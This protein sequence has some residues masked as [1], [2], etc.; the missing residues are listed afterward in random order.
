MTAIKNLRLPIKLLSSAMLITVL[1]VLMA[2]FFV[3]SLRNISRTFQTVHHTVAIEE[4]VEDAQVHMEQADTSNAFASKAQTMDELTSHA[5]QGRKLRNQAVLDLERA[6]AQTSDEEVSR[7]LSDAK[8]KITAYGTLSQ[9]AFLARKTYLETFQSLHADAPKLSEALR[10]SAS[11]ARDAAS[12]LADPLLSAERSFASAQAFMLHYLLTNA[13][14][15]AGLQVQTIQQANT[16]VDDAVARA[17]GTPLEKEVADLADGMQAYSHAVTGLAGLVMESDDIWLN[18]MVS[19]HKSLGKARQAAMDRLGHDTDTAIENTVARIGTDTSLTLAVAAVVLVVVICLNLLTVRLV[20]RPILR[21]T[22]VMELLARGENTV[23]VPYRDQTDEVGGM[24]Q[25]VQI[26][27]E[28]ALRLA[29]ISSEQEALQAQ[30]QADKTEALHALADSLENSVKG[31]AE[32]VAAAAARMQDTAGSL[33][34]IAAET[35]SQATSVAAATEQAT[36][37]VETVAGA[38]E[39]L[40]SSIR[41]IGRQVASATDIAGSAVRQTERTNRL[42]ATLAQAAH[43]IGE[44]VGLITDIA[45]QTNL[46]ALNATIEAARAGAAG[47]GFAVVASEVKTLANQ[48]SQATEDIAR[49]IGGVQASTQEAVTAIQAVSATIGEISDIQVMIASSMDQQTAATHEIAHN[50]E[51]AA[52]GTRLVAVHIAEVTQAAGRAGSGADEMVAASRDLARQSDRLNEEVAAF[53]AH[54]RAA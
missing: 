27:K 20:S 52:A 29:R 46:L 19:A 17:K 34:G 2:A 4:M 30:A 9:Q 53:I 15:D 26:F 1:I 45:S 10:A 54:I 23:E 42:V 16:S 13:D 8:L 14:A 12:P 44:I 49:Q 38:A 36:H 50:V 51:Q 35:R 32:T 3:F 7:L 37:N 43:R 40:S 28:N 18:Q 31:I 48:T 33:S 25:T 47:K 39:E 22:R 24:A 11:H 21:V 5:A 41:E 6:L